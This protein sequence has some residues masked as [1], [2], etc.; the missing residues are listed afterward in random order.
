MRQFIPHSNF[1]ASIYGNNYKYEILRSN[2][3]SD[4]GVSF[5]NLIHGFSNCI[6]IE[7]EGIKLSKNKT[8]LAP[9]NFL[10]FFDRFLSLLESTDCIEDGVFSRFLTEN[11]MIERSKSFYKSTVFLKYVQKASLIELNSVVENAFKTTQSILDSERVTDSRTLRQL[12]KTITLVSPYKF[13]MTF[14]HRSDDAL[15]ISWH[16]QIDKNGFSTSATLKPGSSNYLCLSFL[17]TKNERV[18]AFKE[19]VLL[20]NIYMWFMSNAKVK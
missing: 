18:I 15:P 20:F 5:K 3:N 4:D 8:N 16:Q 14:F 19:I 12:L 6:K 13:K 11:Q 1:I 17:N 7:V 2:V 9:N 10:V